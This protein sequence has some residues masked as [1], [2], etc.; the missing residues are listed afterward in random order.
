MRETLHKAEGIEYAHGSQTS[1]SRNEAAGRREIREF[2][3]T[4]PEVLGHPS[5]RLRPLPNKREEENM[6]EKLIKGDE[7]VEI[8]GI[9]VKREQVELIKRTI[10]IGASDDELRL[11]FY[12]CARRGTHPMDRLIFPVARKDKDGN[13]RVTFQTGIDYLRAAGEETGRYVGQEPFTFGP[14][15]KQKT[16]D[17]DIE[18]PEWAEATVKRKDPET[19]EVSQVSHRVYWKEFY[20]GDTL[21]FMWRKM[22]HGQLGKCAEAGAFRKGFP[23]KLGGLYVNEE[24]EQAEAVPFGTSASQPP[25]QEPKK[26]INGAPPA[27]TTP[28]GQNSARISIKGVVEQ[29]QT[30]DKKTMKSPLYHITSDSD[31][32]YKT[33]DKAHYDTVK[34]EIGTGVLFDITYD[35]GQYGC[36]LKTIVAVDQG[37]KE[38]EDIPF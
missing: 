22:P 36:D 10:F 21:G 15:I 26:K 30:K 4:R 14:I 37:P 16:G 12:E 2:T 27:Q 5:D 32:D 33:F 35:K 13:R 7:I 28:P 3:R 9:K 8:E 20:P 19:G 24:M 11:F 1:K 38:Q 23:R 18:V 31:V 6:E 29:T 34:P 25:L 17:G